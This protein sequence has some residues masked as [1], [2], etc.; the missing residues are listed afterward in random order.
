[1][2]SIAM[3]NEEEDFSSF[4]DG[5]NYRKQ[6]LQHRGDTFYTLPN[7]QCGDFHDG[8]DMDVLIDGLDF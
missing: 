6:Q 2:K 7:G 8:V 4:A 3:K 1:M 5:Y